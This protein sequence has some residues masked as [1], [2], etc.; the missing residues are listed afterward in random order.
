LSEQMNVDK[1]DLDDLRKRE[2]YIQRELY[3]VAKEAVPQS[4]FQ[5]SKSSAEAV[6]PEMPMLINGKKKW[7]D[8]VVFARSY[9]SRSTLLVV[10][11]KERPLTTFERT[12]ASAAQQARA[13]AKTLGAKYFAVYD[14]W[15]LLVFRDI[16]P[17]LIGIF[18]AEIDRTLTAQMV[19]DLFVGLMEYNYYNR[20]DRLA[21]LPKVLDPTLA[22]RRILPSIANRLATLQLKTN[23]TQEVD[24]KQ[25]QAQTRMLLGD[26]L[27][28]L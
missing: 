10:E 18:N 1:L 17:Y 28:H 4:Q 11:C 5:E 20:S 22:K 6:I 26:W 13:Y 14:G 8:L 21:R 2:A 27:K 19:S 9:S 15:L 16:S 7:A 24:K 25:L 23:K 12:Y 3:R